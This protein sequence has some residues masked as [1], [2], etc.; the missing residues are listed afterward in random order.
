MDHIQLKML[1][2]SDHIR[3][4]YVKNKKSITMNLSSFSQMFKCMNSHFITRL[5]L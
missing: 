5:I 3:L 1:P 2:F 4:D